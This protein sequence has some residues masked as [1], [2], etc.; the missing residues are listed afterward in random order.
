MR[1]VALLGL[2]IPGTGKFGG[3]REHV[4]MMSWTNSPESFLKLANSNLAMK[5]W[6]GVTACWPTSAAATEPT[7]APFGSGFNDSAELLQLLLVDRE[8]FS[9][10]CNPLEWKKTNIFLP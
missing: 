1:S 4:V 7:I 2:V 5:E 3:F 6:G 10:F 9:A 8:K